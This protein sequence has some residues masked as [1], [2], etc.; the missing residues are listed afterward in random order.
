MVYS[1]SWNLLSSSDFGRRPRILSKGFHLAANSFAIDQWEHL[2]QLSS[3]PKVDKVD[4]E[5][6]RRLRW[7]TDVPTSRKEWKTSITRMKRTASALTEPVASAPFRSSLFPTCLLHAEA[8]LRPKKAFKEA[9]L[10]TDTAGACNLAL[11]RCGELAFVT[12]GKDSTLIQRMQGAVFGASSQ[13]KDSLIAVLRDSFA[14]LQEIKKEVK[15]ISNVGSGIAAGVFN[16]G[17]ED[18]RHLVWESPSA[19]PIRSTLE[20]CKLSLTHL[21]GDDEDRIEKALEAAKDRP[22]QAAPYCSK[23]SLSSGSQEGHDYKKKPYKKPYQKK[24]KNNR[25]SGK[26]NGPASKKGQKKK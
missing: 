23:A 9:T 5:D 2:C 18:L 19:K 15:R 4:S 24:D 7:K 1:R 22:Y 8:D 13:D 12:L 11:V 20:V 3:P 17:V 21:F 16:Q 26:G 6:R 10:R 25:S 14:D